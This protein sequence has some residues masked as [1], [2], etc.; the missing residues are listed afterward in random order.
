ML[1]VYSTGNFEIDN[2]EFMQKI[3]M[4]LGENIV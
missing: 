4:D 2:L 3:K 1:I